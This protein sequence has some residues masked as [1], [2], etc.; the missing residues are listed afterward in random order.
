MLDG[1]WS[2]DVCSSDLKKS[3]IMGLTAG[4]LIGLEMLY[5]ESQGAKKIMQRELKVQ[6]ELKALHK[7]M[8]SGNPIPEDELRKR[9]KGIIALKEVCAEG[10]QPIEGVSE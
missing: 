1:D 7:D 3:F 9:L 4:A 5:P 2:S 8:F 10:D 6:R